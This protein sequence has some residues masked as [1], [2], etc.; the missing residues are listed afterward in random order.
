MSCRD[1]Q[2]AW[3]ET[4][5]YLY[6]TIAGQCIGIERRMIDHSFFAI[7]T[8]HHIEGEPSN[9]QGIPGDIVAVKLRPHYSCV[10]TKSV[11]S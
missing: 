7:S 9:D 10:M 6:R 2:I 11:A 1:C 4:K 3:R 8:C 5:A